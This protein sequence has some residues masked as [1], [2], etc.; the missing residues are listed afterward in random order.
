[1][2]GKPPA[3]A[4]Q[5][6][7]QAILLIGVLLLCVGGG[8]ILVTAHVISPAESAILTATL[9]AGVLILLFSTWRP[10]GS[11]L[12]FCGFMLLASGLFLLILQSAAPQLGLK[13]LWPFFVVFAGLSVAA[14]G[15]LR[16]RR[17][18]ASFLIPAAAL[19]MLGCTFLPFSL[20]V[21]G[22]S[23][24]QFVKRA[25]PVILVGSGLILILLYVGNRIRFAKREEGQ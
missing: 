21:A 17:A 1:M 20:G 19:I 23:F 18:K 6:K 11:I 15:L 13:R 25:W 12:R 4:G 7:Q 8:L 2:D 22:L 14:T 16:A 5:R 9:T 24:S 3:K 10:V